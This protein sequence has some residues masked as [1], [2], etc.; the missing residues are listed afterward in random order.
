MTEQ[1]FEGH[2][3]HHEEVDSDHENVSISPENDIPTNEE[4]IQ[5]DQESSSVRSSNIRSSGSPIFT[6]QPNNKQVVMERSDRFI[7]FKMV[8][9]PN[10]HPSNAAIH[11]PMPTKLVSRK[12]ST[13][14]NLP[15]P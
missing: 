11:S 5:E 1:D 14:N 12:T 15:Q 3:H 8:V 10:F 2:D 6:N 4:D 13:A 9:R 7:I